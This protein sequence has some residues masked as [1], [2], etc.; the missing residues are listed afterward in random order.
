MIL[1]EWTK[2]GASTASPEASELRILHQLQRTAGSPA[3]IHASPVG[4]HP[5]RKGERP[6]RATKNDRGLGASHRTLVHNPFAGRLGG[7]FV[8]RSDHYV[9]PHRAADAASEIEKA[10][11]A[12]WRS[13]AALAHRARAR[14]CG[15]I[16]EFCGSSSPMRWTPTNPRLMVV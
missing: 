11:P 2:I 5:A 13:R 6:G 9:E 7:D 3:C 16:V 10:L 14:R 1:N 4:G 15:S 12:D 8:V